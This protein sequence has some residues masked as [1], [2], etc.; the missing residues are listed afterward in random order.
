MWNAIGYVT[1][2]LTLLAFAIAVGAWLYR[3]RLV[4]REKS[5][6]ALPEADRAKALQAD[7]SFFLVD[8]EHFDARAKGRTRN[9]ANSGTRAKV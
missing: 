1:T 8:T 4:E 5:L 2:G 7:I 6:R 3:S 9:G